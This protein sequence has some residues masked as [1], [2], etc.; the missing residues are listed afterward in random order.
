[1]IRKRL[2]A[3]EINKSIGR[4]G[5]PGEILKLGGETMILYL[6][7]LQDITINNAAIPSNWKRTT[8]IPIYKEGDRSLDTNYRQVSLTSVVCKQMEHVIAGYLSKSGIRINV[9]AKVNMH[10]DRDTRSK[11]K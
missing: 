7:R 10:L 3:I 6:A 1:M 5:F 4:T 11:V 9:Y 8:V 2:A